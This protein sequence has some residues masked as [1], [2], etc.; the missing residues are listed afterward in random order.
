MV[1][2]PKILKKLKNSL[3]EFFVFVFEFFFHQKNGIL[4][5]FQY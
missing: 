4:L 5:V 2:I 3:F 1:N